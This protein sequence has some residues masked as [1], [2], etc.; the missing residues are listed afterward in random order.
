MT[1]KVLFLHGWHSIVGG[2]KP[3]SLQQAG[4]HVLNPALDDDDFDRALRTAQT[5][6]DRE[7]PDVVVG[8]SRGGA[9]A[10][11]LNSGATPIVLLC[12]AWKNWGSA[13]RLKPNSMILHS[14][15]DDVIP[16]EDSVQLVAQS[17]L[18]ADILIE[19]GQDHRLADEQSL[20]VLRWAC[21]LFCKG[22]SIPTGLEDGTYLANASDQDG[23]STM[24]DGSYI[25][26]SCGEEIVIPLDRSEGEV[27]SYVEDCPVCCNPNVIHVQFD[28]QDRA[29]VW[30]EPEQDRDA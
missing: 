18:P 11:N 23:A 21:D 20:A 4:F 13:S 16:F 10:M 2:V 1:K 6:Y 3:T 19:V 8:S 29:R 12:P 22:E 5:L 30:A 25:C 27:Q 24:T 26:D 17:H 28:D 7:L 15:Q 9:I 14:R